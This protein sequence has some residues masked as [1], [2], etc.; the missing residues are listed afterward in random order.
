MKERIDSKE[1]G[2]RRKSGLA[3]GP[4]E[5]V[6]IAGPVAEE[7]DKSRRPSIV[8]SDGGVS[9][10]IC[11][12]PRLQTRREL[13]RRR[14]LEPR[15]FGAKV[16]VPPSFFSFGDGPKLLREQIES[17]PRQGP[18]KLGKASHC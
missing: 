11:V 1:H 6:E 4:P 17:A 2:R 12:Q 18:G 7:P 10:E 13:V 16:V 8:E 3:T 15:R 9:R 14:K 5:A